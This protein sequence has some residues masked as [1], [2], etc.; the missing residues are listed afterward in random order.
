MKLSEGFESL[1]DCDT[2]LDSLAGNLSICESHL[3]HRRRTMGG[4]RI[5]N[6]F[7]T[8]TPIHPYRYRETVRE[9]MTEVVRRCLVGESSCLVIDRDRDR[10]RQ[11]CRSRGVGTD[12]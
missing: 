9:P 6:P 12:F 7:R 4:V 10:Q 1:K 3:E 5:S 8:P 11:G 2:F